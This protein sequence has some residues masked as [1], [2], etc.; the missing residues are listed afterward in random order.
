MPA[1]KGRILHWIWD[2]NV[3]FYGMNL[4]VPS[5]ELFSNAVINVSVE[6]WGKLSPRYRL[7]NTP[8]PL[9]HGAE[10]SLKVN[11]PLQT[12]VS[13]LY[14]KRVADSGGSAVIG[15]YEY[16]WY[17]ANINTL[18]C[19]ELALDTVPPRLKAVDESRWSRKGIVEFKLADGESYIESFRGT[20]NGEF[21]LFKY[22]SKDSRLVLDLKEEGVERGT[23]TL[24]VVAVDALGNEMVY[25]K[26]FEY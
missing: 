15:K 17:T 16:G 1:V 5:K 11:D 9:W 22:S 25:E 4:F 14:I 20:L 7:C 18:D 23:H 2:N 13:K 10:L 6:H 12:D 26:E 19:Y 24:R 3:R 21:I 8:V